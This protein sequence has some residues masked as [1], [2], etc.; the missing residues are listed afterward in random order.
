MVRKKEEATLQELKRAELLAELRDSIPELTAEDFVHSVQEEQ[1]AVRD[2]QGVG[3]A[4]N[5]LAFVT[6]A[7]P[8]APP[9][10]CPPPLLETDGGASA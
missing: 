5:E 7:L 1:V 8:P 3:R 9:P 6:E 2:E 10:R 4:E